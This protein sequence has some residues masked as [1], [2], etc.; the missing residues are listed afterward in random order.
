M[1]YNNDSYTVKQGGK[2]SMIHTELD[3]VNHVNRHSHNSSD[4]EAKATGLGTVLGWC[5]NTYYVSCGLRRL[6][7][8]SGFVDSVG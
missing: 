3:C 4:M 1:P 2:Q 5:P 7:V 8:W 6:C